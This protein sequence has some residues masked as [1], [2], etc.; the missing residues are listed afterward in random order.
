MA[1][2]SEGSTT[3]LD[4]KFSGAWGTLAGGDIGVA[5]G[6]ELRREMQKFTPSELL[7]SNDIGGDRDSSGTAPPLVA[8]RYERDIVSAYA[9]LNLPVTKALELQAALRA[10]RYEGVG[11]TVNPKLGA[12]WRPTGSLLVRASA[13]TGFRAPSFSELYRP[14]SFG[15]SPAFL[16][17]AVYDAFDQYPTNK[18]S[19]PELKPEKSRQFSLGVVFE[20]VRGTSV[21]L[22][23]WNIRKTDVISDLS[24]KTILENPERYARFIVRDPFDD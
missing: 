17:D 16:Y 2:R 4:L 5:F 6:A 11:G 18:E 23:Y 10:D 12:A 14:A 21:S 24:G 7:N 19:N 1:R 3:G 15:T 8:T 22:D 9:E 20:P 13:G